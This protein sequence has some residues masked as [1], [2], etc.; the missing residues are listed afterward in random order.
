MVAA[1][2]PG[3][4]PPR[5]ALFDLDGTLA[6]SRALMFEALD[7]A[8]RHFGFRRV[9]ETEA[10]ALRDRDAR[11]VLRALG[12][13]LWKLPRIAA[14]IKAQ[15]S[16]APAPPLFP[17]I[18]AML[19]RLESAGVTLALVSSNSEANARRALGA[20]ADC[21][22]HWA[23]DATLF[24]K[25]SRFRQVLRRTGCLP[26]EAIAI[27]D[28]LRDIAAARSAGLTAGAVAWGY[29]L[30][31]ALAAAGPDILFASVADIPAFFG[32]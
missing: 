4:T 1:L 30:P 14:H 13:P 3:R 2:S 21:I 16:R 22:R 12:V 20:E 17:G 18:G 15:A 11:A 19:A 31:S 8:A 32:V 23:C 28:E 29:A 25:A 27:G 10:E 6:D 7:Q 5:L 9:T 24:G 26:G